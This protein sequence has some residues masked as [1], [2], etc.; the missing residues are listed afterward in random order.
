LLIASADFTVDYWPFILAGLVALLV[1]VSLFV[2]SDRGRA[3]LQKA[4]LRLPLVG[5][6][7]RV[8]Y[9]SRL[10]RTLGVMLDSGIPLLDGVGV[11]RGTV[12][13]CEYVSFLEHVEHS[14]KEGRNL[15]E[16][17]AHS[18]LFAP[19]VKQMIHT[20]EMTGSTGMVMLKMADHYEEE[21]ETRLKALTSMLEPM[22][23]V[24]MGSVV[25]FITMSLFL[26][27]FKLSR[28][29]F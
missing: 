4:V 27:L 1:G 21:V 28:T 23:V 19:A 13:N 17:F 15:S 18:N 26:P 22:I 29:G 20:A 8:L 7:C 14:V 9:V 10:L 12:G 2:R 16:S 11:T 3:L 6:A 5:P 25:G 24:V